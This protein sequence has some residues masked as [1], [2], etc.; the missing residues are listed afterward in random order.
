MLIDCISHR[1]YR[2]ILMFNYTNAKQASH[3]QCVQYEE[4]RI[5]KKTRCS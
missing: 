5:Q 3:K 2:N 1:F 4:R